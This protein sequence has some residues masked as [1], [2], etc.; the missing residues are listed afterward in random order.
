MIILPETG[1]A[2]A[3]PRND[4]LG[5]SFRAQRGISS[6][7]RK[8]FIFLC[9]CFIFFCLCF[10]LPQSPLAAQPLNKKFV[11]YIYWSGIRAGTAVLNFENTPEG[12]A[13]KT[14]ATSASFISLFYKV[15]DFA[16]SILYPDGYPKSFIL[17]I[18]EGRHKRDKATY[19]EPL[20]DGPQKVVYHNR[21]DNEKAEFLL[22]KPVHDLL[23]AFYAMTKMPLTVG[24]SEYIDI[25]DT[26]KVWHTEIQVLRK[27]KIRVQMRDFSTILVKP[28]IQS[29]GLFRKTGDILIWAT[30][31]DK[32]L[33][34]LL[35]SK[36]VI[37]TFTVELAEGDY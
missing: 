8:L 17:K 32:K 9:S 6:L 15:E 25:F 30:D 29:E 27:E 16:Q 5:L 24:R 1:I 21:L 36:A 18:Q 37:G 3:L 7:R 34:V 22:D 33:P 13:I 4:A 12:V 31:D 14:L 11:Y 19:F 23:S 26:K 2:S 35:K 10:L 28:V 20:T